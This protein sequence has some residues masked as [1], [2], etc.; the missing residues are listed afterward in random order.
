MKTKTRRHQRHRGKRRTA[1]C[2][3]AGVLMAMRASL[4]HGWLRE[5][6]DSDNSNKHKQHNG[7]DG[8]V[9][10]SPWSRAHTPACHQ[11]VT[12]TLT[13]VAAFLAKA[14]VDGNSAAECGSTGIISDSSATSDFY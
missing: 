13:V 6:D 7:G 3:S 8:F 1:K 2:D 10:R 14:S 9:V 4:V 12:N 11:D 5:H